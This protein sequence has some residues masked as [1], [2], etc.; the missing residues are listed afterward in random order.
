MDHALCHQ[1]ASPFALQVAANCALSRAA[2]PAPGRDGRG[3]LTTRTLHS[4]LVYACGPTTSIS[5]SLRRFG[6]SP[7]STAVV[8]ARFDGSQEQWEEVCAAVVGTRVGLDHLEQV[9]DT[10]ALKKVCVLLLS[11]LMLAC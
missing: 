2:S 10:E 7:Q 6:V 3:G 8:V 5:D 9:T 4:E 11:A 1:V